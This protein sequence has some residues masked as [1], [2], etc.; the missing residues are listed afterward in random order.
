[1]S[2][3]L[4]VKS[5]VTVP[6]AIRQHLRVEPGQAIDYEPLPDG[7][8]RMF[9]VRAAVPGAED[10]RAALRKWRGKGIL[11]QSTE[12]IMR[13]TRGEDAMR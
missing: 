12:E 3:A 4:T 2:Y 10:Y 9:A 6:K 13:F 8:V 1:M 5:Q 7:S 11:K